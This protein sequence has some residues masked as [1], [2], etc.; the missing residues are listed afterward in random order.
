MNKKTLFQKRGEICLERK[1]NP[2]QRGKEIKENSATK[3]CLA[4]Q[5]IPE[6]A[7]PSIPYRRYLIRSF[8]SQKRPPNSV[9]L[10]CHEMTPRARFRSFILSSSPFFDR[11]TSSSRHSGNNGDFLCS[12]SF[13][14]H[15]HK[16]SESTDLWKKTKLRKV[17]TFVWQT[18]SDWQKL[19]FPVWRHLSFLGL[20][21]ENELLNGALFFPFSAIRRRN[22]GPCRHTCTTCLG[23]LSTWEVAAKVHFIWHASFLPSRASRRQ[24]S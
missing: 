15:G 9:P 10:I 6:L 16:I 22:Y 13:T 1:T 19:S 2:R 14:F 23:A 20:R 24:I 3:Q 7:N 8:P 12:S 21:R 4:S 17:R 18:F 11:G 5:S